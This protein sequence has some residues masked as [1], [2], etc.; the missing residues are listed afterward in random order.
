M[1]ADLSVVRTVVPLDDGQ[2]GSSQPAERRSC[3]YSA[4]VPCFVLLLVL[5]GMLF[6]REYPAVLVIAA[7]STI[8]AGIAAARSAPV[9]VAAAV[10]SLSTATAV[11]STTYISAVSVSA[12]AIIR[13]I[14]VTIGKQVF[15]WKHFDDM[16]LTL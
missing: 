10:F 5:R 14:T 12:S 11:A 9:V 16:N 2:G 6:S 3:V 8:T 15:L 1:H 13:I 7:S 4:H